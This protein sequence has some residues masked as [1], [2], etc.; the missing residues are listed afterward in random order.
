MFKNP[1][2]IGLICLNISALLK[3]FT[4]IL[5]KIFLN[6]L[7]VLYKRVCKLCWNLIMTNVDLMT[8]SGMDTPPLD[9]GLS[10]NPPEYELS[11]PPLC[12][13]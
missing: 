4:I 5:T 11:I 6:C 12:E 8:L 2:N 13:V 3:L 7:K 9:Y 1:F 10:T